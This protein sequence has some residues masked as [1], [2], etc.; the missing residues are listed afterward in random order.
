M[1][2]QTTVLLA[3]L[4]RVLDNA[5]YLHGADGPSTDTPSFKDVVEG[6]V[7]RNATTF[8]RSYM[9]YEASKC[10]LICDNRNSKMRIKV[11]LQDGL[12][13]WLFGDGTQTPNLDVCVCD[14]TTF[15]MEID[16]YFQRWH[17]P[18]MA[19][20]DASDYDRGGAYG[21]YGGY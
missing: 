7:Q 10:W 20:S 3:R 9:Y 12:S 2:H 21:R 4:N 17:P 14:E 8:P 5:D 18:R 13:I 6:W 1:R 19:V 16:S 15:R 11:T